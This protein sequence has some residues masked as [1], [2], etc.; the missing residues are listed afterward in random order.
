[1]GFRLKSLLNFGDLN[2]GLNLFGQWPI[3]FV[4][5]LVVLTKLG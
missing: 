1:M 5:G 4:G 3:A 2:E